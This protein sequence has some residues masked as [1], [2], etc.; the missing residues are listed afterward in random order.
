MS[1][2]I[3][4]IFCDYVIR[5]ME[6]AIRIKPQM[7]ELEMIDVFFQGQEADYFHYLLFVVGKTFFDVIKIGE[8]V[9]NGIEYEKII[10]QDD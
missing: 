8:M 7:K 10:S 4:E 2:I 3:I 1:K 5:W 6:Q 9:K